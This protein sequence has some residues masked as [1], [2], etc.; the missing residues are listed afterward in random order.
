[1]QIQL[2]NIKYY[3]YL[4]TGYHHLTFFG[5]G[6]LA[7]ICNYYIEIILIYSKIIVIVLGLHL[8]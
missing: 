1:M 5:L 3:T 2:T 4:Y 7:L 6:Y 8:I